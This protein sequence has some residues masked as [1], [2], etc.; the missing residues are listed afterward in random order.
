[1]LYNTRYCHSIISTY[2]RQNIYKPLVINLTTEALLR[3][4]LTCAHNE[5]ISIYTQ[6]G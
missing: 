3:S 1:M 4:M 6:Q 2:H 5:D